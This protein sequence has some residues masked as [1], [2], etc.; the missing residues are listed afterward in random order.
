[1]PPEATLVVMARWPAA[2]RCKRRLARDL[3]Q[4]LQ[5][6]SAAEQAAH[7]QRQLTGHTLA[8]AKRLE[9]EGQLE[10]VL[11]VSG[12]GRSAAS[13]WA[14][15][16]GVS[17][18]G[19]LGVS[20]DRDGL[21]QVSPDGTQCSCAAANAWAGGRA[22]LGVTGG[23]YY[24]EVEQLSEGSGRAV[25]VDHRNPVRIAHGGKDGRRISR[26]QPPVVD[27]CQGSLGRL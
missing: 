7:I 14:R 15:S 2:G 1:M 20:N 18:A 3:S 19:S 26:H 24:F 25:I 23:H 13:R 17:S 11:A 8:V 9:Q 21:L 27:Q 12:A 6:P 5:H 10:V 4:V 16:L 22:N